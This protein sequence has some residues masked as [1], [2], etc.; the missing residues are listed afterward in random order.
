MARYRYTVSLKLPLGVT[1]QEMCAYIRDAVATYK[2]QWAGMSDDPHTTHFKTNHYHYLARL[3]DDLDGDSIRVSRQRKRQA[4]EKITR[5]PDGT[6]MRRVD[7]AGPK[8]ND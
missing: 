2:G 8:T 5:D 3:A 1:H 7:G 4:Q 6:N